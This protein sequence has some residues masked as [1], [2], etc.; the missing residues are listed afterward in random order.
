MPEMT[1]QDQVDKW[2]ATHPV[3][4]EVVVWRDNGDALLTVTRSK[5]Q[6]N[7][8]GHPWIWV[9]GIAGAYSLDCVRPVTRLSK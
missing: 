1:A 6:G 3:G 8:S 5:A 7:V 4:I 9:V 2:N